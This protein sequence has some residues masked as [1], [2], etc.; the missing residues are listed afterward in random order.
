MKF[1]YIFIISHK[2]YS[3]EIWHILMS[4]INLYRPCFITATYL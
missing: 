2:I 4:V 3:Y 1:R